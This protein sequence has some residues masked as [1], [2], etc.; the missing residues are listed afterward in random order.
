MTDYPLPPRKPD[1][2]EAYIFAQPTYDRVSRQVY[3]VLI[4]IP[5]EVVYV[6]VSFEAA[7]AYLFPLIEESEPA[8]RGWAVRPAR[9]SMRYPREVEQP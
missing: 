7:C 5:L 2:F 6:A 4:G 9:V 8:L 1:L 3:E